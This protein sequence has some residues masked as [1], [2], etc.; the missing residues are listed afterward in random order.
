M[1]GTK[2]A[3]LCSLQKYTFWIRVDG[4]KVRK[5]CNSKIEFASAEEK[6]DDR[7]GTKFISISKKSEKNK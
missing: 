7:A 1:I 5:N 4:G 3:Q 6:W 2:Y